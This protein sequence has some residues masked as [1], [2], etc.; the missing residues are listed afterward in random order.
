MFDLGAVSVMNLTFLL[1]VMPCCAFF[2]KFVFIIII[3]III[4]LIH[5]VLL[6]WITYMQ[7]VFVMNVLDMTPHFPIGVASVTTDWKYVYQFDI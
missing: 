1:N 4:T 3:I 6:L 5:F 2:T 7:N